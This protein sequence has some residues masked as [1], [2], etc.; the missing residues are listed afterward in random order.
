MVTVTDVL[1]VQIVVSDNISLSA[2][3]ALFRS[4]DGRVSS[5]EATLNLDNKVSIC[6]F[7]SVL[8]YETLITVAMSF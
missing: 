7:V 8:G 6:I 1:T 5:V 4:S 2:C 3:C